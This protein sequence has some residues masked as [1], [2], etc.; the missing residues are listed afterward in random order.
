[1]KML[2]WA[3][4]L[5][6]WKK[7]ILNR[8]LVLLEMAANLQ[9][10]HPWFP[11]WRIHLSKINFQ[12]YISKNLINRCMCLGQGRKDMSPYRNK[13]INRPLNTENCSSWAIVKTIVPKWVTLWNTNTTTP[14]F[15]RR[16]WMKISHRRRN[17]WK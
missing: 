7:R 4:F 8:D 12:A 11:K 1:M 15:S 13:G 5:K 14:P 9:L 6:F 2:I 16:L 17:I 3:R 10:L